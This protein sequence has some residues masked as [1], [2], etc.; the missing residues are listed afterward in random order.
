MAEHIHAIREALVE[1]GLLPEATDYDT[2]HGQAV[3]TRNYAV[4]WQVQQSLLGRGYGVDMVKREP[5]NM[6]GRPVPPLD[7]E[8]VTEPE[9]RQ[10]A[11]K[12]GKRPSWMSEDQYDA[13]RCKKLNGH[14]GDHGCEHTD[15][16]L[17]DA[18]PE[19]RNHD[20]APPVR[21]PSPEEADR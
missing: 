16:D 5:L 10:C 4:A 1:C 11:G 14:D 20:A 18:F 13:C 6:R 7:T 15:P 2:E 9:T 12:V 3:K 21:R 8:A 17:A 19:S